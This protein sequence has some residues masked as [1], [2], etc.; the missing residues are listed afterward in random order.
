MSLRV[1]LLLAAS[2]L[3]A[4]P[5]AGYRFVL[6]ME[7]FLREQQLRSATSAAHMLARALE[8]RPDLLGA[9]RPPVDDARLLYVHPLARAP[10]VDG[11]D[12]DWGELALRGPG[13]AVRAAHLGAQL[14]L[15]VALRDTPPRPRLRLVLSDAPG[16]ARAWLIDAAVPGATLASEVPPGS[17]AVAPAHPDDRVRAGVQHAGADTVFEIRMPLALHAPELHVELLDGAGTIRRLP[18][19]GALDVLVPA[20]ELSTL[21]A[22]LLAGDG[23]RLRVTDTGGHVLAQAGTLAGGTSGGTSGSYAGRSAGGA[24]A[25]LLDG[26]LEPDEDSLMS[27]APSTLTL[28]GP[29]LDDALAGTAAARLRRGE[30]GGALVVSATRPL[31][32]GTRIVGALVLEESTSP[33]ES[34]ARRALLEL[35]LAAGGAFLLASAVLLAVAARAASRLRALRDQA[36]HAIDASGRVGVG[37]EAAGGRDEI[38]DLARS[39]AAAL[40]RLRGYQDY[41]EQLARRLSHELRTPIAVIRSSLENLSLAGDDAARPQAHPAL[42]RALQGAD[43]LDAMVRRMSEAARLELAMAD[44]ERACVDL[45]ALVASAVEGHAQAIADPALSTRLDPQPVILDASPDLLLQA[46]DKLIANARDFAAPGSVI[47]V[48]LEQRGARVRLAV[49]NRGP[50]LPAGDHA[51]LFDSMVSERDGRGDDGEPH[52]G[53]GLYVV[54]LVAQFHG[55]QPFAEDLDGGGARVGMDLPVA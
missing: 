40:A 53:L 3:L 1:K 32:V 39:F 5:L 18:A 54:R 43:R 46:L 4:V 48:R 33:I 29:E 6:G 11:Y 36:A 49:E 44:S 15:L 28:D 41:L 19:R 55:G 20:P 38:G 42:T 13:D 45:R 27:L 7:T 14:Y 22:S 23:R 35:A 30:A 24:L 31:R 52:L 10:Q 2:L 17:G 9:Y 50:S 37:F 26:L 51:R 25:A 12:A 47:T 21:V 16:F 34:L 8:S